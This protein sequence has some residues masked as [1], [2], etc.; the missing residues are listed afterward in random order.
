MGP[1]MV[2]V[3]EGDRRKPLAAGCDGHIPKPI[4]V[5]DLPGQV[6]TH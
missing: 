5:D 1:I 2:N 4:E 6:S 3:L